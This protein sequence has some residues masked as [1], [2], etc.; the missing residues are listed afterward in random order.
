MKEK[1][2]EGRLVGMVNMKKTSTRVSIYLVTVISLLLVLACTSS[3]EDAENTGSAASA[4]ES[5]LSGLSLI[6]I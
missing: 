3:G 2:L 6:H 4:P 1:I 5:T